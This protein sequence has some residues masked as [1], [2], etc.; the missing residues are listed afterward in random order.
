MHRNADSFVSSHSPA[1]EMFLVIYSQ[2]LAVLE[3]GP[4]Y[5]VV[6]SADTSKPA[7]GTLTITVDG[8]SVTRWVSLPD[9]IRQD[10]DRQP[11][12]ILETSVPTYAVSAK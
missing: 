10:R 11:L 3:V 4:D 5:L 9:G 2:Q 7:Q 6:Q 12:A 8:Q 1:I